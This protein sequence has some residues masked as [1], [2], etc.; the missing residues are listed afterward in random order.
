MGGVRRLAVAMGVGRRCGSVGVVVVATASTERA[1]APAPTVGSARTPETSAG[2]PGSVDWSKRTRSRPARMSSVCDEAGTYTVVMTGST[3]VSALQVGMRLVA[4]QGDYGQRRRPGSAALCDGCG[5]HPS[6]VAARSP[7]RVQF[8]WQLHG[9][10]GRQCDRGLR[11]NLQYAR[12]SRQ[13]L[14]SRCR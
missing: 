8:K 1:P 14:S 3:S 7:S 13:C 9:Q 5:Q 11:G 2:P 4:A 10:R 12:G 6:R